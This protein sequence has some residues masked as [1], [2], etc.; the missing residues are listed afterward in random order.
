MDSSMRSPEEPVGMDRRS[1]LRRGAVVGGAVA[2]STPLVQTIA[3]PAFAAGSPLCDTKVEAD[4]CTFTYAASVDC[5]ECV[6]SHP[7]L[8]QQEA[9]ARCAREGRCIEDQ[10]V[11]GEEEEDDDGEDDESIKPEVPTVIPAGS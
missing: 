9:L 10:V 7:G 8:S 5:C 6:E 1:L 4:D 3:S 11:C 2:W